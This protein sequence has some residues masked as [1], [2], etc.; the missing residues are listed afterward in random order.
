MSTS[1]FLLCKSFRIATTNQP[2]AA[3]HTKLIRT[4]AQHKAEYRY[5]EM[6]LALGQ[7]ICPFLNCDAL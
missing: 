4:S 2:P 5:G 3:S 7:A 1:N 6:S